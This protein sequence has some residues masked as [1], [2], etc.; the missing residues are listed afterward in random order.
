MKLCM[1][2]LHKCLIFLLIAPKQQLISG[3]VPCS[4]EA[5]SHFHT[6]QGV[7]LLCSRKGLGGIRM[8][9]PALASRWLYFTHPLLQVPPEWEGLG[10][11]LIGGEMVPYFL[12]P[13]LSLP[14]S[15]FLIPGIEKIK[16]ECPLSLNATLPNLSAKWD[17]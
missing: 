3:V 5:C 7:R 9:A 6:G 10:A 14:G 11:K 4:K 13:P 16:T 15:R 8:H 2:L 12:L 1:G 17:W